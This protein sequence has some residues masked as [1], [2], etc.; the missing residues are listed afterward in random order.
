VV[1]K[2]KKRH[3]RSKYRGGNDQSASD[4]SL[5][6]GLNFQEYHKNQHGGEAPLNSIGSPVIPQH[7]VGAAGLNGLNQAFQEI[8]GM[9]D[10]SVV[11]VQGQGHG[12][13]QGQK[14][15]R[16]HRHGKRYCKKSHKRSKRSK[17][18]KRSKRSKGSK[19]SK[20]RRHRGGNV[21]YASFPSKGMLLNSSEYAQA[22]LSPAWSKDVAFDAAY[23]RNQM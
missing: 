10:H 22:G 13:V 3:R 20:S 14:G 7:M 9:S 2:H 16:R 6:Q 21:E 11:H 19:R 18:S 4:L 5:R 23:S 12:Q 8:H 1:T 15:G 17:G